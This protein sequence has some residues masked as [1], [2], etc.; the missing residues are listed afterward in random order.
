MDEK[1]GVEKRKVMGVGTAPVR[2]RRRGRRRRREARISAGVPVAARRG[3]AGPDISFGAPRAAARRPT[4]A[5]G[6]VAGVTTSYAAER[7]SMAEW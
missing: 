5:G 2:G 4:S 7:Q 6:P 3:L 1:G